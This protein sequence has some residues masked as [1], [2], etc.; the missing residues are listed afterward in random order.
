M[1]RRGLAVTVAALTAALVLGSAGGVASAAG[2]T[3]TLT[4]S[5][6]LSNNQFVKVD[7][8]G[9]APLQV[10]FFRQCIPAPTNVGRDCTAIY[11]DVG[12]TDGSGNGLLY[13]HV[14]QGEVASQSG[15]KFVCDRSHACK[16]GIFTDATREP[17]VFASVTPSA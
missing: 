5:T 12:F 8:S 17:G 13:E 14:N 6:G 9:Y 2:G 11:S 10:V 3:I 15:R 1:N 7:W 16:L 4:P